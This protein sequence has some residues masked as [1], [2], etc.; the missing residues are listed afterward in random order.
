MIVF[1]N[2]QGIRGCF[3][4]KTFDSKPSHG[5]ILK[6]PHDHGALPTQGNFSDPIF[7]T[8]FNYQQTESVSFVK[9]FNDKIYTYAFGHDPRQSTLGVHFIGF[10]VDK[11]AYSKVVES[12]NKAY[13]S[14]RVSI[15]KAYAQLGIGNSTPLRGFIMQMSSQTQDPETS[16]QSFTISMALVEP[17]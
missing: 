17:Q 10:L 9:T 14:G 2:A 6:L 3:I 13:K 8:G 1:G 15:A 4:A 12:V 11:T 5:A 7:V 16:L